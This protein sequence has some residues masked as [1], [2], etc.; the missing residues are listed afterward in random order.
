M[1]IPPLPRAIPTAV[2]LSLLISV[3]GCATSPLMTQQ[4]S[5]PPWLRMAG[6][7]NEAKVH[8]E[9]T[10]PEVQ[11]KPVDEIRPP[12]PM[13]PPLAQWQVRSGSYLHDTLAEWTTKAGWGFEWAMPPDQD[14]RMGASDTY[15]GDFKTVIKTLIDALPQGVRIRAELRP[16]NSPPLL[17]VSAE[18]GAH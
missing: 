9:S 6:N 10:R 11:S 12:A 13:A 17:Y 4:K 1:N 18:E 7:F 3:G 2:A 8:S 5:E 16:D 14:F 15:E